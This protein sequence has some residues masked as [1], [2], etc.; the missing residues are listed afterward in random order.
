LMS[1]SRGQTLI[2]WLQH[3]RQGG[4]WSCVHGDLLHSHPDLS[5]R[6]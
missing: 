3:E 1:H 6:Q 4:V 2:G 5:A